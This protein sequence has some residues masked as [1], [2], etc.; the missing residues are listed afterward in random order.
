MVG[1]RNL[2]GPRKHRHKVWGWDIV[3]LLDK[4]VSQFQSFKKYCLYVINPY[5]FTCFKFFVNMKY[6]VSCTKCLFNNFRRISGIYLTFMFFNDFVILHCTNLF[7][8]FKLIKFYNLATFIKNFLWK[9]S[10][11]QLFWLTG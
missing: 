7:I 5:E 3:I 8:K 4:I 11:F 1:S 6:V 10:H 2:R 9:H